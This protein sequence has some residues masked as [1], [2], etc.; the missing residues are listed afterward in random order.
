[1]LLSDAGHYSS[2]LC[3][4][5]KHHPT[6]SSGCDLSAEHPTLNRPETHSAVGWGSRFVTPLR[7]KPSPGPS[8]Y[9]AA[10]L[11]LRRL[12]WPS[13]TLQRSNGGEPP[14]KFRRRL[15]GSE[16]QYDEC[17]WFVPSCLHD[18][19]TDSQRIFAD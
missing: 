5:A 10:G 11:P 18:S 16:V 15:D 17:Q 6:N 4:V 7:P 3:E 8:D 13:M 14:N 19:Y 2:D 12:P 9:R 1:M